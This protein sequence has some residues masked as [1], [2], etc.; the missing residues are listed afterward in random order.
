MKETTQDNMYLV[1]KCGNVFSR[2]TNRYLKVSKSKTGYLVVNI[3]KNGKRQ[4]VYIHRLVA[5]AYIPNPDNKKQVNHIDGDKCNNLVEN[6]EWVHDIEN[7]QHAVKCGLTKR[8]S[9]LK[10][11]RYTEQQVQVICELFQQGL[12]VGNVIKTVSFE[13]TKA[14]L[15]NIRSRRDWCHVSS[16]YL[17]ETK[18][19]Y[20]NSRVKCND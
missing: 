17:W 13:T 4:P 6:L 15:L 5:E 2:F 18:D 10:R 12:S 16:E 3:R 9:E 14:T 8:G 1:D 11:S 20:K 7:K 19:K